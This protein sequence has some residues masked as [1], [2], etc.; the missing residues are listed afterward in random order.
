MSRSNERN[1]VEGG[2]RNEIRYESQTLCQEVVNLKNSMQDYLSSWLCV[3]R[4]AY[5]KRIL[6]SIA[7]LYTLTH[8]L[9]WRELKGNQVLLISK[10]F[11]YITLSAIPYS[12]IVKLFHLRISVLCWFEIDASII[13]NLHINFNSSCY[14]CCKLR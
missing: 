3:I 4:R 12:F 2:T 7:F 9:V 8:V 14:C 10:H 6:I 13:L 1:F 11:T 5:T